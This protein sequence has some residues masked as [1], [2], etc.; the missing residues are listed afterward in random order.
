M[1][2][3]FATLAC[4]LA[5]F[6]LAF[7]LAVPA[8]PEVKFWRAVDQRRDQEIAA[9]RQARPKQPILFFTGGSSCA[10]S[11]DPQIIE[12]S[13]GMPAF[14]LGLPVA[15]GPKFILHQALAKT[16]PGDI[17]VVCLESDMLTHPD[18]FEASVISFGLA[19]LAGDPSAAAG[20][21]SF[22]SRLNVRDFINLA[23]PGPF[24]M[25]TLMGK[26]AA[27]KNL[28]RYQ[29]GDF[30]HHGRIET[31]ITGLQ[32]PK[33]GRKS[34]E[35]LLPAARELLSTFRE[36]ASRKGVRL[37]Y[38]MPWV[39]TDESAATAN[40]GVNRSI[41]ASIDP[42]LPTL[43]DGYLGLSTDPGHFSDS[44]QH[45]SA[46]G[47]RLRSIGLAKVLHH[48]LTSAPRNSGEKLR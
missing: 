3:L 19:C 41:L 8:N 22:D 16:R 6:A 32:L 15:A 11:I 40:H 7:C 33:A 37:A 48:W 30:R 46:Q 44:I 2:F 17:L 14:N 12:E 9:V 28:Y 18:P 34:A 4:V 1:R 26:L 29:A 47:S 10:F 25:A 36:A 31:S 23:R 42:I 5:A 21:S 24:H 27:G 45:L 43:D 38:S 13:C 20:G 39:L 35:Q